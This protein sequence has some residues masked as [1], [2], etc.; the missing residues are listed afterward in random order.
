[1]VE[2]HPTA[3]KQA[4]GAKAN[5]KYQAISTNHPVDAYNAKQHTKNETL[6]TK[7]EAPT[8]NETLSSL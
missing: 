4:I 7:A 2:V 1:M 3:T 8:N 5:C 6:R